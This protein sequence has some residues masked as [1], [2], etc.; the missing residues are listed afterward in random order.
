MKSNYT[1][2]EAQV[3]FLPADD[4]IRTS[5]ESETPAFMMLEDGVIGYKDGLQLPTL[6]TND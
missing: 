1:R 6:P 4:V 3:V 5:G 2:A